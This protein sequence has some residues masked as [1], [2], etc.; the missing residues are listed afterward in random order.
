MACWVCESKS[1]ATSAAR[2]Q[3]KLP[4]I[5][6]GPQSQERVSLERRGD[7]AS[8]RSRHALNGLYPS[9][10]VCEVGPVRASNRSEMKATRKFHDQGRFLRSKSISRD[11]LSS[12]AAKR[13]CIDELSATGIPTG[14]RVGAPEKSS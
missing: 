1:R 8:S 9:N 12:R 2:I 7:F 13:R 6:L 5:K 11:R 3:S 10:V 4:S 14:I